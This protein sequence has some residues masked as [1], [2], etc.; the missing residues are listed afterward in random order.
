M[1]IRHV[2]P[3][4]ALGTMSLDPDNAPLTGIVNAAWNLA[5][6][7]AAAGHDVEMV[8]PTARRRPQRGRVAGVSINLQ[9]QWNRWRLRDYDFS[10][11]LPLLAYTARS[12]AVETTHVHGNPY[13]ALRLKTRRLVLHFQSAPLAGSPRYARAVARADAII[14]C[15]NFTRQQVLAAVDYPA[16]R[17]HVVPNGAEHARF[18]APDRAAARARFAIPEDRTVALYVGR[19]GPEKGLL[20]LIEALEQIANAGGTPPLLLVAGSGTLGVEAHHAVWETLLGYE[21][22][23]RERAAPLPVRFL[24]DVGRQDL[25]TL[26]RAADIFVCPSVWE[27]PFGMVVIEAAAAGL[28]VIAS[29]VGGLPEAVATGQTALL[30]PPGDPAALA[31]ALQR[32]HADGDE[33][34]RLGHA[35]QAFALRFDWPRLAGEAVRLYQ[36]VVPERAVDTPA[37][38]RATEL[39]DGN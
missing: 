26:Y 19:I 13:H 37:G 5:V 32:L 25:P 18:A 14:C 20:V 22:L 21:R 9:P 12:G 7:Q 2:L 38:P 1:R 29:A 11:L 36:G 35:G 16:T 33:R 3:Q 23:V 31:G 4:P 10:A 28:P 34:A 24:G 15:S 27:E 8:G 6:Q 30:V 39:K 17:V